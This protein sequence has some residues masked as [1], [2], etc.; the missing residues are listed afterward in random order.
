MSE[1]FGTPT[2][3]EEEEVTTEETTEDTQEEETSEEEESVEDL[4]AKLQKLEEERENQKKRAEK[5]E[6]AAKQAKSSTQQESLSSSDLLFL[7]KSDIHDDDID[8]L[9]NLAKTNGISLKEAYGK[10]KAY[11]DTMNEQRKSA[12][13]AHTKGGARGAN[14]VSGE[15]LLRKAESG[16][17]VPESDNEMRA[18][19]EARYKAGR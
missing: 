11:F 17:G 8:E 18:L 2:S 9:Q 12:E 16:K 19:A 4:K 3:T 10:Y 7:A 6:K 15:D 14:K 5:A 1:E 13:V